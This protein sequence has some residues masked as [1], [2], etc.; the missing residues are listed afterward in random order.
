[1]L[2]ETEKEKPSE[3]YYEVEF[4][5]EWNYLIEEYKARDEMRWG[6]LA[7]VQLSN[8]SSAAQTAFLHL[9]KSF[10]STNYRLFSSSSICFSLNF[11]LFS[12]LTFVFILFFCLVVPTFRDSKPH[13]CSYLR[14]SS[15]GKLLWKLLQRYSDLKNLSQ[16][17]KENLQAVSSENISSLSS[18]SS[19]DDQRIIEKTIHYDTE[20]IKNNEYSM[21][22]NNVV[23][24]GMWY[25]KHG[26]LNVVG[27]WTHILFGRFT[28]VILYEICLGIQSSK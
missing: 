5:D 16:Q 1:V 23:R 28:Q 19:I 6:E 7:L 26:F 18:L 11:V 3:V 8:E 14:L 10:F 24:S 4:L 27:N 15:V 9:I 21:H 22:L 12:F 17:H 2:E 13:W 20:A 25:V